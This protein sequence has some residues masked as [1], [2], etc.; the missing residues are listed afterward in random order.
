[1]F[2]LRAFVAVFL[3]AA[4]GKWMLAFVGWTPRLMMVDDWMGIG[5][6]IL[7][8]FVVGL[9]AGLIFGKENARNPRPH[10]SSYDYMP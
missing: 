3:I 2:L 6:V 4:F 1:M 9:G 7:V 5:L 10:Y 8:S